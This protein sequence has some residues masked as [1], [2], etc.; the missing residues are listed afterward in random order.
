MKLIELWPDQKI[1]VQLLWEEQKI[2]FS[3]EVIKKEDGAIYVTP[4]VHNGMELE[5]N[6]TL[7]KS[8]VC[9]VFADNPNTKQR[10]SWKGVE[11]TTV[12]NDGKLIYC[13][14][15]RDYN[16]VSRLDDR[17][18][19]E[20]VKV[21]IEAVVSNGQGE[22]INVTIND[23]SDKGISFYAPE[24][25]NPNSQQLTLSFT[26]NIGERVYKLKLECAI[27]RIDKAASQII[28]GC[29]ILGENKD[30][31]IYELLKRLRSKNNLINETNSSQE[32]K[33]DNSENAEK[34]DSEKANSEEKT[35]PTTQPE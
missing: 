30:Y 16:A 6:I 27:S 25:F 28:V 15:T 35:N 33:T 4:Y 14:K 3:S 10:I 7:D 8:V 26:D 18:T 5:L 24:A 22:E 1:V 23:I 2:E 29:R 12:N 19:N 21:M 17:R 34:N 20:R 32:V 11:L 31:Q 9:N 13:L